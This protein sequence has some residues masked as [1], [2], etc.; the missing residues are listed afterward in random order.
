MRNDSEYYCRECNSATNG[1]HTFCGICP[2]LTPI[3]T[4][5]LDPHLHRHWLEKREYI[6]ISP[7]AGFIERCETI[8][9][10]ELWEHAHDPQPTIRV[11][12]IEKILED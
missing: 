5:C 11:E 3:C 4:Y 7:D 2:P 8:K 6:V 1:D 9:K 10:I 12:R